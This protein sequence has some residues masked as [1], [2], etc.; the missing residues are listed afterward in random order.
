MFV[1]RFDRGCS[2]WLWRVEKGD[3]SLQ[4]KIVLIFLCAGSLSG[5]LL[6]CNSQNPEPII[7]Q[8]RVL[9]LQ[10]LHQG[11]VHGR[12]F[13]VKLKLRALMEDLLRSTL[14]QEDGLALRILDKHRHHAPGEI[15][16]DFVELL[17]LLNQRLLV[18]IG[19]I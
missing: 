14:C 10:P 9:V 15:E 11:R 1:Q 4:H 5:Q 8:T 16:R 12:Q 7:A 3:I 19:A 17:V 18:E 13:P 2:S 6:Y